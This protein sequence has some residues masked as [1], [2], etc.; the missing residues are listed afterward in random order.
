M[1]VHGSYRIIRRTVI[2]KKPYYNQ[3]LT[4][5]REDFHHI[6][7]YCGKSEDVTTK[8]F[9]IDHFV[10]QTVSVSLKNEYQNLIYSCFTCN[11]K[12][13]SKWPTGDPDLMNDGTVGFVDPATEEYDK[14]LVRNESGKIVYNTPLGRYLCNNVFNFN[15]RPT[16]I[17][18][19]AM[20]IVEL[21]RQ[22]KEKMA[23]ISQE[24]MKVYMEID[25]ELSTLMKYIFNKKE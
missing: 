22:L 2:E 13:G 24:E 1:R 8:G 18:W 14:H 15:S 6:C 10:P 21:K 5:L 9:E 20:K 11:R 17:V 25:D 3:Y 23:T 7:G 16:D 12:K 4:E 19:K